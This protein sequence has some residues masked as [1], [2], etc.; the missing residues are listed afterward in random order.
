MGCSHSRKE[1]F[2]KINLWEPLRL[3]SQNCSF[4]G[5]T[6]VKERVLFP[7]EHQRKSWT[8]EYSS[9]QGVNEDQIMDQ[10]KIGQC[11]EIQT[12]E[13]SV[14]G[15]LKA[16]GSLSEA[17]DLLHFSEIS[18]R[19]TSSISI[20][21]KDI[22]KDTWDMPIRFKPG[23]TNKLQR[24]ALYL[25]FPRSN[26]RHNPNP[27]AHYAMVNR[28]LSYN[29]PTGRV[30]IGQKA[31]DTLQRRRSNYHDYISRCR[32]GQYKS[33]RNSWHA[34]NSSGG[35]CQYQSIHDTINAACKRIE[36]IKYAK[37]SK[38]PEKIN[39]NDLQHGSS[40]ETGSFDQIETGGMYK[41]SRPSEENCQ[42]PENESAESTSDRSVYLI[43]KT[44]AQLFLQTLHC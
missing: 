32:R 42:D 15:D 40:T 12:I 9:D 17:I 18:E 36:T 30:L 39:D 29:Y 43:R 1:N 28:A 23:T 6:T 35:L 10:K 37:I 5:S 2:T 14:F 33:S 21:L 44:M 38:E 16:D 24:N 25:D 11:Q 8:L 7:E 3:K 34:E 20:C 41:T 19:D 31:E 22:N 13:H 27:L 4:D 26:G